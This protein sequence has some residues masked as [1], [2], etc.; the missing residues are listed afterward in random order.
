METHRHLALGF[1]AAAFTDFDPAAASAILAPDYIQHN[2]GVPTGAEPVL[3]FIPALKASGIA[4]AT[5]RVLTDGNFVV[6]HNTYTNA[7]AFGAPTL[8]AFDVFRIENS[9]LAEHWDNLQAPETPNAS[10]RTL[11][12]GPT[13]VTDL[14]KTEANKARVATF[15]QTVLIEGDFGR[16][17][18]F[19]APDIIQ[20]NPWWGD[21]LAA[22]G[23]GFASLAKQGK[24]IQYT[25]IHQI[26]GEGNFVLIMA[27]GTLGEAPTAYYDL[28]R[29]ENGQIVEHWDVIQAIP[30]T[31]AHENGK[32]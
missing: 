19:F 25:K 4:V 16:I 26:I 29:L 23:A 24:A 20:H 31:M 10:G 21:G 15:A 17:T 1:L 7:H 8:V 9:K 12:D 3:Q 18:D 22:L 5:H 2:P 13:T 28:F 14:D 32:F 30:A 11:T 6:T 27:E